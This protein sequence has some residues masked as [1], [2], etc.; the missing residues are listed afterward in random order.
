MTMKNPPH[1]GRIIREDCLPELDLKVGAAA[2][3][4]GVSRQTLDKI[5]NE[6]GGVTPDMAIRFEK[7]FGSSAETWLRLQ[8][9]YDLAQART[10]EPEIV[11]TIHLPAPKTAQPKQP[12]LL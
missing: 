8:L 5:I 9:A 7:V 10:R 4:L 2:E 1:P 6:R 3:A 12:S 11:A